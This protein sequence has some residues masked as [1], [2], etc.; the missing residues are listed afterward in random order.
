[1]EQKFS[2][3]L[4]SEETQGLYECIQQSTGLMNV[5]GPIQYKMR[6]QAQ[7]DVYDATRRS[8][9]LAA[10]KQKNKW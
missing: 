2:F 3:Q 1:M 10:E 5:L 7:E 8:M 6:V 9:A 4:D